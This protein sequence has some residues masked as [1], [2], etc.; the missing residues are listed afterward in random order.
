M[1][2]EVLVMSK[3]TW[4][5]LSKEDQ[6]LIRKAAVESV[7]VMRDLWNQRVEKSKKIVMANGNEVI[8]NVDKQP[9]IDAMGPVYERFANT[10]ELKDLVKRIQVV[11]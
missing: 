2:P 9:F 7:Q 10:P 3:I 1:S 5:K 11:K 6:D 8:D 4:D